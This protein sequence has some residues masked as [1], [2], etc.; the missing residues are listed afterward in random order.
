[1]EQAATVTMLAALMLGGCAIAPSQPA[2]EWVRPSMVVQAPLEIQVGKAEQNG[3]VTS[4]WTRQA[5]RITAMQLEQAV[6]LNTAL[7]LVP[8][9][10]RKIDV[11]CR[12]RTYFAHRP[13]E[14]SWPPGGWHP[15]L[16]YFDKARYGSLEAEVIETV[17]PRP[18]AP[19]RP[20]LGNRS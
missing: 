6:E 20:R 12:E 19:R 17:C 9:T 1:M 5:A 3:A 16:P 4:V 11:N 8:Y 15:E 2:P 13:A 14:A 7:R 10:Y 18:P